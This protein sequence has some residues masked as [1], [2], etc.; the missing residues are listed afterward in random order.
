MAASNGRNGRDGENTIAMTEDSPSLPRLERWGASRAAVIGRSHE[1]ANLPCQDAT[2]ILQEGGVFAAA[3][4]DGAGS[5]R[6]S[7]EGA[8][9]AAASACKLLAQAFDDFWNGE[10]ADVQRRVLDRV[11][12]GLAAEAKR[13]AVEPG[14][15]ASTLLFVAVR[16]DRFLAGHLGDGVIGHRRGGRMGIL[17]HPRQGEFANET[18]FTT[19]KEAARSLA[20][21]RGKLAEPDAMFILMSDG[22][23]EVLYDRRDKSLAPAAQTM[24][25]WLES[26]PAPAVSEALERNMRETFRART[27]DDCSLVLLGRVGV[28]G[29]EIGSK[30]AAFMSDFLACS[31]RALPGRQAVA[32]AWLDQ[33]A[34]DSK[35]LSQQC[36]LTPRTVKSHLRALVQTIAV[37]PAGG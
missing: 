17:S 31:K 30:S 5:R 24:W 21:Y 19:S 20:L 16:D 25:R 11:T 7:K 1:E 36:R 6:Y 9:S 10:P 23:A 28:S 15:L 32:Q 33:P 35:G 2:A 12:E 3:L 4:A 26:S 18:V 34:A 29:A 37:R 8:E 22:S 27:R 13:L 14:E